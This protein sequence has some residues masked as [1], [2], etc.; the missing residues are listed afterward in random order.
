MEDLYLYDLIK[1]P[2]KKRHLLSDEVQTVIADNA[3][4]L[5][6]HYYTEILVT[7]TSVFKN[8]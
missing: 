2:G 4:L 7:T 1:E 6:Q 8:I 3:E 5:I